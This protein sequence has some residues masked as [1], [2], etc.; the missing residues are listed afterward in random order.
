[1]M[2]S[3]EFQML[4]KDAANKNSKH[5]KLKINGTESKMSDKDN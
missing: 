3:T 1:M 4:S 5:S 2:S